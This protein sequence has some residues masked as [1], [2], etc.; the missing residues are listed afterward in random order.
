MPT[1]L[2]TTWYGVDVD[3]RPTLM[4]HVPRSDEQMES[5]QPG[6]ARS[7]SGAMSRTALVLALTFVVGTTAGAGRT[8]THPGDLPR[9][10]IE[11]GARLTTKV[12]RLS[13]SERHR[14][15]RR[16]F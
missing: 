2:I 13:W 10:D 4:I 9:A 3:L 7:R 14:R 16:R 8:V 5:I 1:K 6:P 11:Y 12:H 15:Q